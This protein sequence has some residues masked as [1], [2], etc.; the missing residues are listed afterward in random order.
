MTQLFHSPHEYPQFLVIEGC[1]GS[2]KT[3]LAEGIKSQ[4]TSNGHDVLLTREPG[5]TPL[6]DLIRQVFSSPPERYQLTKE[7]ELLL[8]CAARSGHVCQV[9][10]PALQEG[11]IVICDRYIDSTRVYQGARSNAKFSAV[12]ENLIDLTTYGVR[13]SLTLLLHG[14][15]TALKQRAQK[16]P[17]TQK[18]SHYDDAEISQYR[19]IQEEYQKLAAKNPKSYYTLHSDR[20]TASELLDK[21]IIRVEKWLSGTDD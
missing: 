12:I 10:L 7:S 15:E 11:K 16:N 4:L 21:A 20:N 19:H 13:P 9:I 8:F 5:G 6:G 17:S 1:D 3:T 18:I 14:D 2:G